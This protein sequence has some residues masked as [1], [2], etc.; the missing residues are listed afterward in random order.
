MN[1]LAL[2]HAE[3]E[4]RSL[5]AAIMRPA[6]N[7]RGIAAGGVGEL[8]RN[9]ISTEA[10]ASIDFRLVPDQ[11]PGMVRD[12]VESFLRE[13]GYHVVHADPDAATRRAH[14]KVV[15]LEWGQGY[16]PSRAPLDHPMSRAVVQVLQE[17]IEAPIVEMPTLGGS[18]PI[19]IFETVL[20]TPTIGVPTVNHDNNQHGADENLR[21]GNLWEGIALYA[22]LMAR[23]GPV[24]DG[25]SFSR[26]EQ[27]D[28]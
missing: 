12:Q 8:S 25:L 17:A 27:R 6:M 3:G 15:K 4:G 20:D 18:L 22:G 2:S 26:N 10:R 19:Y 5:E 28:D 7:L 13:T 1:D 21:L 11:T 24:W 16:P 14:P 23:L 9:A